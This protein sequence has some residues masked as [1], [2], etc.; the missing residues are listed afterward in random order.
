MSAQVQVFGTFWGRAVTAERQ[1]L[2]DW[3]KLFV[4][5]HV[6]GNITSVTPAVLPLG[7]HTVGL[8]VI[9]C[10]SVLSM[11]ARHRPTRCRSRSVCLCGNLFRW[12]RQLR[13]CL[14]AL[15]HGQIVRCSKEIPIQPTSST[16][17]TSNTTCQSRRSADIVRA[18]LALRFRLLIVHGIPDRHTPSRS[19]QWLFVLNQ[20]RPHHP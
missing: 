14:C 20:H 3:F 18:L 10:R 15:R 7:R 8:A 17:S 1:R 16:P 9:S 2:D 11:A 13:V 12:Y 5:V 6:C 4:V 19:V